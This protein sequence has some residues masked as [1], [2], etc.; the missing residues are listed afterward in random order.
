MFDTGGALLDLSFGFSMQ[1]GLE[2][3]SSRIVGQ[4]LFYVP[5]LST[6]PLGSYHTTLFSDPQLCGSGT[7][8]P[9]KPT[10]GRV[11]LFRDALSPSSTTWKKGF[12]PKCLNLCDLQQVFIRI[13]VYIYVYIYIY[14]YVCIFV[15]I[16]I[17]M[18]IFVCMCMYTCIFF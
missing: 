17:Y 2:D 4:G 8:D 14:I 9:C 10:G 3:G 13:Y 1:P 5:L 12:L 7:L 15:C 6:L 16:H 18:Y 11:L